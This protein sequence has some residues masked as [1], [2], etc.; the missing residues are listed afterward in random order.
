MKNGS[1]RPH[2]RSYIEGGRDRDMVMDPACGNGRVLVVEDHEDTACLLRF[3][4]EQEDYSVLHVADG[5]VAQHLIDSTP[6]PDLIILDIMLPSLTGL[7]LLRLARTTPE[8][9]WLPV[10]LLTADS[11]AE[12]MVEAA[13]LGATEYIQKPF[14]AKRLLK[15]IRMFLPGPDHRQ[16]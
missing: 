1:L 9:Q 13:N 14:V 7:E 4:L 5:G 15:S 10:I 2:S 16:G 12:T 6:P 8:W 11:R 3:L